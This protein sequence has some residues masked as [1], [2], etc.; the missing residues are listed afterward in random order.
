ML[1]R[2]TYTYT[3]LIVVI[4]VCSAPA[5]ASV[6][7]DANGN[8][9]SDIWEAR[10]GLSDPVE[11]SDSDQDGRSSYSLDREEAVSGADPWDADSVLGIEIEEP[12]LD[13]PFLSWVSRTGKIGIGLKGWIRRGIGELLEMFSRLMREE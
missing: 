6:I 12:Q 3:I 9:V 5:R 11:N 1:N 13:V 2:A 7:F 8:G 4:L 10:Y